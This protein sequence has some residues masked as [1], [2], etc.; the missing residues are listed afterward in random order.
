MVER[1]F[2]HGNFAKLFSSGEIEILC[3][4]SEALDMTQTSGECNYKS[5][6]ELNYRKLC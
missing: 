6:E 1:T 2:S 3:I 5:F 4:S